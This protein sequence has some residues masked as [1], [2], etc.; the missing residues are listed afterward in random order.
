MKPAHR[1]STQEGRVPLLWVD[2]CWHNAATRQDSYKISGKG[3][4]IDF[5]KNVKTF[6]SMK[7]RS[8]YRKIKMC[9]KDMVKTSP[10]VHREI[11]M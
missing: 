10:V 11:C 8:A 1:L 6:L 5:F 4:C 3:N 2:F 7:A 9:E